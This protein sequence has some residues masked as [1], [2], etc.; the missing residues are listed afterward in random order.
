MQQ[1]D[2]SRALHPLTE[3]HEC[4]MVQTM[5]HTANQ[6]AQTMFSNGGLQ[7]FHLAHTD[8]INWSD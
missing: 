3:K 4:W 2:K 6:C 7:R 1:T 8:A 5:S